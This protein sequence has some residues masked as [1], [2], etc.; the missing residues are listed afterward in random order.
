LSGVRPLHRLR[1]RRGGVC[2][3]RHP[4]RHRAVPGPPDG[5]AGLVGAAPRRGGVVVLTGT[6]E[7][8]VARGQPRGRGVRPR[9][10][11][12]VW[13]AA[14]EHDPKRDDLFVTGRRQRVRAPADSRSP[15]VLRPSRASCSTYL[16]SSKR[17]RIP[18]RPAS[19]LPKDCWWSRTT[20]SLQSV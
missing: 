14:Q 12:E 4:V 17:M 18:S 11:A 6:G 1:R 7:R 5:Q 10:R 3:P 8:S 16:P 9:R 20:K 19:R 2:L 13:R 15:L